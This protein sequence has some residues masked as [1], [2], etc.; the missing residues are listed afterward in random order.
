MAV[1]QNNYAMKKPIIIFSL[2]FLTICGYAQDTI[3]SRKCVAISIS[4]AG[5][6]GDYVSNSMGIQAG[7][8]F[9]LKNNLSMQC[10]L[11]YIFEVGMSTGYGQL[12]VDV[13]DLNGI[14]INTE[15]KK[16]IWRNT[17]EMK[18]GYI[19]AQGIILHTIALQDNHQIN[20]TKIGLSA[21]IGW[22]YIAKSGFLF[23]TNAGLGVQLIISNSDDNVPVGY[24]QSKEF[25]WSKQYDS[26]TSLLPDLTWNVRI[27]WCF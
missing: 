15:V 8:E 20:R 13:D 9:R 3:E 14:A 1:S 5:F 17:N 23:E 24:Y 18:G 2:L 19:G 10:D 25:P 22:K 7:V 11:R 21:I 16:Y 6:G 12:N 26:G 27:G 4:L